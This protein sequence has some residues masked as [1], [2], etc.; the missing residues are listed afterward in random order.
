M[1]PTDTA[2]GLKS[3]AFLLT[4][5]LGL[6]PGPA[7]P[8]Q[9]LDY[10]PLFPEEGLKKAHAFARS[11]FA[12]HDFVDGQWQGIIAASDGKTYFSFSS[13]SPKHNAQFYRYDPKTD[14]VEHLI[15]VGVWCGYKDSPGKWNAQGKIHSNIYEHKGKLYCTTTSAHSSFEHPYPGGHFL[16]YDLKTGVFEDLAKLDLDGKGGLLS[17]VFEP[18]RER[19]YAIH[20]HETT[21]CYY[22]LETKKVTVVGPAEDG[23]M[24]CR[25]LITDRHG[26]VYGSMRDGV[27]YRYHPETDTIGCL[28]T[29]IPH[30]PDAKQ[31]KPSKNRKDLGWQTTHWTPMV[32]DPVTKWWYGVRGNDE[33]LFRFRP[34]ENSRRHIAR[35]EGLAPF[36]FRPST[37]AQPRFASLGMAL[38]GRKLYYCSYPIWRSMAHLMSY[39]IDTGKVTNHGPVVTDGCRRVSE[40]HAMVPSPDGKLH[41]AAMVWSIEGKDPAKPWANRAQCYFH[42]RFVV[43]DP[44]R[45]F[46]NQ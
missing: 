17:A 32:W 20:Q 4:S 25:S 43:V 2:V 44:E 34:P 45:S 16:A 21:L 40:I 26:V 36:G 42:S 29:R 30:D 31:P 14:K 39:E 1:K 11:H 37:E 13:H 38:L 6:F 10:M 22:D 12:G 5:L 15:D 7:Q 41:C 3:L 35:I 9:E 24:Q 27:I 33:Y 18:V 19:V 8:E 28:L 23:G 46:R